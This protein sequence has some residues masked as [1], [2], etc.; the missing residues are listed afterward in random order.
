MNADVQ[1]GEG[2]LCPTHCNICFSFYPII[3]LKIIIFFLFS[4]CQEI[5]EVDGSI[6]G[7]PPFSLVT[8]L[9]GYKVNIIYLEA[10]EGGH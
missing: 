10:Q 7:R 5:P 3:F 6:E 4:R 2:A 1:Q 9:L 8:D